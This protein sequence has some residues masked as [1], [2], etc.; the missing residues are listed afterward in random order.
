MLVKHLEITNFLPCPNKCSY[1]P[2][3]KLMKAYKGVKILTFEK[4]KEALLNVSKDVTIDFSGFGETFVHSHGHEMVR[5]AY[6]QGHDIIVYTSGLGLKKEKLKGINFKAFKL[7]KAESV[8]KPISRAGNVWDV[9]ASSKKFTCFKS[10]TF[11]RNVMLPNG[12]VH[13][14]CMD[15]GQGK[16]FVISRC[17]TSMVY[18]LPNAYLY[19]LSLFFQLCFLY[20]MAPLTYASHAC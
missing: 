9:K 11:E 17:F 12:D 20:S 16:K 7:H 6:E 5:Y 3:D 18:L 1:C 19:S 10:P 2:Q 4:F 8:K 13:L 15:F 14:C